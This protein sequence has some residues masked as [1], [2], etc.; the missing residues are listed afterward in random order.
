ML[1]KQSCPSWTRQGW[2][3]VEASLERQKDCNELPLLDFDES[4]RMSL[5]TGPREPRSVSRRLNTD[6]SLFCSE[7]SLAGALDYQVQ[8]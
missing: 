3:V 1:R 2:I 4:Y 7:R 8:S 6:L 5:D